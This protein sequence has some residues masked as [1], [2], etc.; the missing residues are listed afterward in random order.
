M[1]LAEQIARSLVHAM[2]SVPWRAEP[3]AQA[4]TSVLPDAEQRALRDLVR[5]VLKENPFSYPPSP[6]WLLGFFSES[7]RFDAAITPPRL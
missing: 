7:W 2:L 1:Q 3:L 5:S 4:A 6:D